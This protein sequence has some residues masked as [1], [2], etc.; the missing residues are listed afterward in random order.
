M[1]KL[2]RSLIPVALVLL[3]ACGD[4]RAVASSYSAPPAP[5]PATGA[6]PWPLAADP[7][8]LVRQAGLNPG[9]MEFFTYH[10]HAH[11][12][13]YVNGSHVQI[14]G[15]IGIDVTDSVIHKGVTNGAPSH[16]G[17][18]PS[19]CPRPCVSPLHTHFVDGVIHIEAPTKKQFTLGQFFREWGVR[20]D[21][22]CVGGYCRPEASVAVFVDGKQ[23]TGNRGD[24]P[25]VDHAEIAVVIGAPPQH[26]PVKY[27]FA[28]GER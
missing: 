22:S 14:P 25:L 6:T 4:G 11:L 5:T 8:M 16:G 7:M 26:I 28:P 21:S 9:T 10:V 18:P 1:K 15:G 2:S 20:L 3:G 19:G 23:Q 17:I 12:D 27:A 13:V 24:I